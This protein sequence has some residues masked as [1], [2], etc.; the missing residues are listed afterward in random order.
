MRSLDR[1]ACPT[2]TPC[3]RAAHHRML[4]SNQGHR[5]PDP[6][7][8][9]ADARK[10]RGRRVRE[11][12]AGRRFSTN[13]RGL[14]GVTPTQIARAGIES[15]GTGHV[16]L[17]PWGGADV[18]CGPGGCPL[19]G[20]CRNTV[21]LQSRRGPPR[22]RVAAPQPSRAGPQPSTA[23]RF[24]G[25]SGVV[26]LGIGLIREDHRF[27]RRTAE[28]VYRARSLVAWR[29]DGRGT[30]SSLGSLK[31]STPMRPFVPSGRVW[32]DD[33]RPVGSMRT[34]NSAPVCSRWSM[35]SAVRSTPPNTG[36]PDLGSA[37]DAFEQRRGGSILGPG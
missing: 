30:S 32:P 24:A 36:R 4:R 26:E 37:S 23:A 35:R 21:T 16:G 27:P 10:D 22:S 12:S 6:K 2:T 28:S 17:P 34:S 19:A 18:V 13:R 5:P 31:A 15:S 11:R 33:R 29:V 14:L 3:P 1:L 25:R 9:R 20:G 7:K 8:Y